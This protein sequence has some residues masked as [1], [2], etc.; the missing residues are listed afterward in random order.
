M[1]SL[2]C[3]TSE[4]LTHQRI[5]HNWW[6]SQ[7]VHL[8]QKNTNTYKWPSRQSQV[9]VVSQH[10]Q[11]MTTVS[12]VIKKPNWGFSSLPLREPLIIATKT[13]NYALIYEQETNN[14]DFVDADCTMCSYVDMIMHHMF[15]ND[16]GEGGLKCRSSFDI[17]FCFLCIL[18][19]RALDLLVKHTITLINRINILTTNTTTHI[20]DHMSYHIKIMVESMIIIR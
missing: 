3:V 11:Q 10:K 9:V 7:W 20:T 17:R 6:Y 15:Y 8:K 4:S 13:K 2:D 1:I 16:M 12:D 5:K 19:K 18:I 14:A